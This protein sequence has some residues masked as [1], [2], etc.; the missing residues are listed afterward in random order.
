MNRALATLLKQAGGPRTSTRA[1]FILITKFVIGSDYNNNTA[2]DGFNKL[3]EFMPYIW[4]L[5]VAIL[6]TSL[7]SGTYAI[8]LPIW[9]Y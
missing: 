5:T 9:K 1:K 6:P 7:I 2:L 3:L 4:K 8:P